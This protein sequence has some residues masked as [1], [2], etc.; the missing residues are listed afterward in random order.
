M[1]VC[2]SN[3]TLGHSV[4]RKQALKNLAIAFV[5]ES[6]GRNRYSF[7]A[8]VAKNESF[9]Q[10][11]EIFEILQKRKWLMRLINELEKK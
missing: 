3:Q 4:K 1:K 7:Y 2:F 8:K 5:G 6:Q 9:E 11:V 10:I